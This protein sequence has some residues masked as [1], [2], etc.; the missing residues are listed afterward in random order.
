MTGVAAEEMAALVADFPEYDEELLKGM[1][2]D[3]AGDVLEL[4]AVLRVG[5]LLSA[6][7]PLFFCRVS[8]VAWPGDL[9]PNVSK[10]SSMCSR[11]D[12]MTVRE[13]RDAEVLQRAENAQPAQSSGA[14]GQEGG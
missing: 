13:W 9:P 1:L 6:A 12:R 7:S 10:S 5:P 2:E 8:K 11:G 3:Q 14:Q 4:R